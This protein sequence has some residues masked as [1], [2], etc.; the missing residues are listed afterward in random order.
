MSLYL[1]LG[2]RGQTQVLA[3]VDA[4]DREEARSRVLQKAPDLRSDARVDKVPDDVFI[5]ETPTPIK[6]PYESNP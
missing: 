3:V 5:F 1:M 6:L 4:K 2:H